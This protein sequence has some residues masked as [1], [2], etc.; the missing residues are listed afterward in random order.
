MTRK[1]F[2]VWYNPKVDTLLSDNGDGEALYVTATGH[3]LLVTIYQV[4][5]GGGWRLRAGDDTMGMP[6]LFGKDW[7]RDNEKPQGERRN[8]ETIRPLTRTQA[9]QWALGTVPDD[10]ATEFHFSAA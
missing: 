3:Y 10:L 9:A 5:D 1:L 7:Q 2:G 4:K 6:S 8:L